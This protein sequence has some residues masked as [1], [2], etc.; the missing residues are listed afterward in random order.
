MGAQVVHRWCTGGAEVVKMWC[1]AR[2]VK[3]SYQLLLKPYQAT[4][5]MNVE[6][7]SKWLR[8]QGITDGM[9]QGMAQGIVL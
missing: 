7:L 5:L 8:V 1:R 6:K 3:P 4:R 9:A 2:P